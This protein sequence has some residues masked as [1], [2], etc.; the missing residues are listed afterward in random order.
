M[1]CANT[2]FAS[3]SEE[4]QEERLF[5]RWLFPKD[6]L[7][8]KADPQQPLKD[9]ER[10]MKWLH[11]EDETDAVIPQFALDYMKSWD[12][13]KREQKR[14]ALQNKARLAYD[15]DMPRHHLRQGASS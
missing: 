9:R 15:D 10:F 8:D 3:P 13:F 5:L 11:D 1:T 7:D 12:A 6:K 14:K 4:A 2:A